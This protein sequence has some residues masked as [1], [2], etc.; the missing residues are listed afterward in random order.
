MPTIG[1][2]GTGRGCADQ[3]LETERLLLRAPVLADV[4]DIARIVGDW[5]VAR[6][7]ANVPHPYAAADAERWIA[8][9]REGRAAGTQ[10]SFACQ[11]RD[12][13]AFVGTVGLR[14]RRDENAGMLGYLLGRAYWGNGYA[15][16]AVGRI[17][18][19]GFDQLGLGT[20]RGNSVP[21][22]IA[23][24][25]VMERV[26]MRLVGRDREP[27]P[28]RGRTMDVEVRA[29]TRGDWL[30]DHALPVV[31]VSAAALVDADGRV[32]LAR[33]PAGRPLA[34]LWEFPGGKL[35]EGETPE[36]AL[37]REL[38][39]EL[40]VDT[41]ESCLAPLSFASHRYDDFHLLLTLFVCRVWDGVPSPRE[42]QELTWAT[43]VRL[44]DYPM[45]PADAPLVAVLRDLL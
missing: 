27:A 4:P 44:A 19:Y 45:P 35:A 13:G 30:R 29:I 23:S 41:V 14:M 11:R 32:L 5:E 26:G 42:G 43:P 34:G 20:V 24:A 16:E 6:F 25:R 28:A 39:E 9:I 18:R 31:L 2:D 37:I 8:E 21:E 33:R 22:N 1:A 10:Y 7:T 12:D 17:L 15:T 36:A 40:G 3:P 38:R